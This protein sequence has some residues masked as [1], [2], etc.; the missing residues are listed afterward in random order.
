MLEPRAGAPSS[1]GPAVRIFLGTEPAQYRAE[2]ILIWSVEQP[3]P[4]VGG[5]TYAGDVIYHGSIDGTL[6]AMGNGLSN[7]YQDPA[8]VVARL[9]SFV[10]AGMRARAPSVVSPKEIASGGEGVC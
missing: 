8:G 3:Y 5:V 9:V 6:H 4:S 10:A 1:D 2:R 7:L